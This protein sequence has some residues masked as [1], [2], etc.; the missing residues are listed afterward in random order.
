[1]SRCDLC[2][3]YLSHRHWLMENIP[4]GSQVPMQYAEE[5]MPLNCS[6]VEDS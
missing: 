3:H 5:L 6:A 1:M 4:V 2:G